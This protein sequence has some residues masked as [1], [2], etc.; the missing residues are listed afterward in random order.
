MIIRQFLLWARTATPGQRAEAVGALARA[1]LYSDLSPDDRWEAETAMTALLDD[2]SPLV[3]HAL[4]EAF[5]NASEAPRHLV[6]ALANDQNDIAAL[7]LSR[8]PVLSDADLVDCA[9]LGDE[10]VQTA[11][12]LR[13]RLSISVSAALAEIAAPGAL[14]A[15]AG[16]DGAAIADASLARM[17][18]RHGAHRELRGALLARPDLPLAI[19][20]SIAVAL[21]ESLSSFVLDCGWLSKERTE[22][23]VREAREKTT[24]ALSS[25]SD[26]EDVRRLVLHL[27]RTGQLT[28][29][30]IL[31][32]FLSRH[33]AFA[34][35][36]LAELSGVPVERVGGLLWDRRGAGLGPLYGK[37]GLP[38]S[39]KP[40]FAA[41]VAALR[42]ECSVDG[43]AASAR[44]SRLTVERVLTACD[45]LP[46]EE[47]GK[48]MALLRR[49]ES[50]AARDE[51]RA[52][53]EALAD[54]A[55]LTAV[56][57]HAP[58]ALALTYEPPA[59]RAA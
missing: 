11:V 12:A 14:A 26:R 51:A 30:L 8:S 2:P 5:A 20:Q 32:A 22:R 29:A 23:I 54:D 33:L 7:V 56:L 10:L 52:V 42:E 31:R 6:V 13:P 15:L 16:N 21:S 44:L 47:A 38:L 27:R 28:P 43:G 46:P 55:A 58:E 3:R 40:A 35:T 18:A 48:L 9:A 49:F 34:E 57:E 41:A 59:L 24:L 17:V 53:A 37:T 19:R 25:E 45:A 1:Y 39:L 36:A 50:E 4:A